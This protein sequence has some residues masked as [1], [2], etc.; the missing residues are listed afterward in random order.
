MLV[1]AS[2]ALVITNALKKKSAIVGTIWIMSALLNFSLNLIL[3]H[4]KV[5]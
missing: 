3:T 4:L 2:E 1:G 5:S